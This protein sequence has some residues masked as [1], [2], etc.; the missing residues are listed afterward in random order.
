MNERFDW[1]SEVKSTWNDV[2]LDWD[3]R[4]EKM[5]E[6]GSR[7]SVIPFVESYFKPNAHVL[8]VGCGNGYGSLK[9]HELGY[10]VVGVD[11][12]DEMVRIA[13]EARKEDDIAF[14]QADVNNLPFKDATFDALLSI[15]VIEWTK[16]PAKTMSDMTRVLKRDGLLC[17]G[18]LGPTA[19]P[20]QH[21]Y[22]RIYGKEVV[23]NTMMP[24]EFVRLAKESGYEL[25]AQQGVWKRE[26]GDISPD[27]LPINL[28]Q[29]ISFMWL[30]MLRKSGTR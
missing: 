27:T 24:W 11:I 17:V 3:R 6:Q 8:D 7:K 29:A 13:R 25:V 20:R 26:M 30:F 14:Q 15:N 23:Q 1:Q 21:S 19:G 2:A 10:D 16:V 28:Q 12:S 5:W 4:S 9:L 22:E 18:I